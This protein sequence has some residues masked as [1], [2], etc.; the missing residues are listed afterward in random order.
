[1]DAKKYGPGGTEPQELR[2][3]LTKPLRTRLGR[4]ARVVEK[5]TTHCPGYPL[6]VEIEEENGK[7][8]QRYFTA[9]GRYAD[10]FYKDEHG[11]L[12]DKRVEHMHDL[13]NV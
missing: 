4:K 2:L 10:G 11:N 12:T 3:D 7:K 8:I 5:D 13:Q 9:D 6:L 1:M